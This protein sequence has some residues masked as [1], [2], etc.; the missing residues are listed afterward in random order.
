MKVRKISI[1]RRLILLISIVTLICSAILGICVY[2]MEKN[3][4]ITISKKNGMELAACAAAAVD[5]DA[6]AQIT[7]GM[8]NSDEFQQVYDVLAGY[9]DNSSIEYIYSMKQLPDES[10]V[11]V[12]DTDT[13]EPAGIYE[14]YGTLDKVTEALTTKTTTADDE[15]TTDEWGSYYSAYSPIYNQAGDAVGIVGVDVSIDWINAQLFAVR[16]IILLICIL[17]VAFGVICAVVIGNGIGKNLKIL[18]NKITELNTGDGDFSKAIR[19]NSGD[20]LEVIAD[21][22]NLLLNEFQNL[23]LSIYGTSDRIFQNGNQLKQITN[24]N[25][26][27]CFNI[28]SELGNI[29]ANMEECAASNEQALENLRHMVDAIQALENKTTEVRT[30][31][32]EI[33]RQASQVITDAQNSRNSADEKIVLLQGHLEEAERNAKKVAVIEQMTER[34]TMIAQQTRILSLNA[35]VEA[36]RAG[37]DGKG[38][39]VVAGEVGKLSEEIEVTVKEISE[40][41]REVVAVVEQLVKEI[42]A[43][44]DFVNSSV[45]E[46]YRCMV[47]IGEQYSANVSRISDEMGDLLQETSQ[48]NENINGVKDGM[49][50]IGKAVSESTDN[51]TQI[52]QLSETVVSGM[53]ELDGAASQNEDSAKELKQGVEKYKITE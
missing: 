31:S 41:N 24:S 22:V 43:I 6:F 47:A 10:V 49:E 53:R 21:N 5:G 37:E 33:K 2:Q 50:E 9:R 17:C 40:A 38:F 11:F 8:E 30:Y 45:L 39:T 27:N 16:N 28:N 14:E 13:E 1:S 29:S 12:V 20:E 52:A 36:G 46:D 3:S 32:D 23:I 4:L 51:I 18:N 48:I 35:R 7:E 26:A 19:M 15:V 42:K 25:T 44:Q 34:I